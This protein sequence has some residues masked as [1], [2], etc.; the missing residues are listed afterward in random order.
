LSGG[1]PIRGYRLYLN[2]HEHVSV[3]PVILNYLITSEIQAG[4]NYQVGVLAF[5]DVGDGLVSENLSI[6]A[7][8]VAKAPS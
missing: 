6:I 8:T 4:V 2:G 7:A 3:G 1:T 5:N